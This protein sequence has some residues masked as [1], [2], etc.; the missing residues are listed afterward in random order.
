MGNNMNM[1]SW[2]I[3]R[4]V[5]RPA[6]LNLAIDEFLLNQVN[7]SPTQYILKFNYFSPPAVILGLNQDIKD[8]NL[9]FIKEMNFD[10]NRRLT[11]GA[12]ILIGFPNQHSQMGISFIVPLDSKLPSKLS[13]KFKLFGSILMESLKSIDLKPIYNRNS[14]ISINGRKIVGNGIYMM[15]NAILFHSV[16]LFQFDFSTTVQILMDKNNMKNISLQPTSFL[17]ESK[18]DVSITQFEEIIINHLRTKWNM[19]SHEKKLLDDE[20]NLINN[21]NSSKYNTDKWKFQKDENLID[22]GS[23]FVP[24]KD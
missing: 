8:I 13:N 9:N 17:K 23:C 22:Q 15:E 4:D 3:I 5:P 19:D 12:A 6:S 24:I 18:N 21:L 14:D 20:I 1:E 10:L 2:R 16:V 7:D 11:G